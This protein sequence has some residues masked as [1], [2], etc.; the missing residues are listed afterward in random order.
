MLSEKENFFSIKNLKLSKNYT[1]DDIGNIKINY[2]DKEKFN[3]DLQIKKDKKN[4][5]ITG[6]NLNINKIITDLLDSKGTKKN[7]ILA[8]I[9]KY[10]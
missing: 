7:K 2:L 1:I 8:I 5:L 3:N 10:F 9:S 4:Y 6:N